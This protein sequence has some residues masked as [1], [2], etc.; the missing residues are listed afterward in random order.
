MLS[1][2][3]RF[4]QSPLGLGIF[5][6]IIVAFIV[7]LYE[8]NGGLG[9]VGGGA[10]VA[11][12]GGKAIDEAELTRRVQNQLEGERQRDPTIDMAKFVAGGGVEQTIDLTATGRALEVFATRQG[13][14]A[15]KKLVDGAIASIPAFNGPTGQFDRA[16]F[17]NVLSSRKISETMLRDD[18]GREALTKALLI[19]ASGAARIPTLMVQPYAS[20]LLEQRQGSVAE[21]PSAAFAGGPAPGDAEIQA[22]YRANIARYTV[23]E[24]RVIRYATFDKTRFAGKVAATDA[25]I[26]QAYKAAGAEYAARDKRAFT[27]VIVPNQADADAVLAKI[28]GGMSIA[29]AA[30][31]V[32]RDAVSVPLTDKAGFDKLTGNAVSAAAFAAPQGGFA[33]VA[34]SALGFHVVRVDSVAT[35]PAT[36]LSA[37]REKLSGDITKAKEARAIADYVAQIEDGIAGNATFDELTKK[38]GLTAVTS[39]ALTRD[40]RSFT[41]AT[42]Q[43]TAAI[44]AVIG[45]AFQSE[46]GDDPAIKTFPD[47]SG[48]ALWKT[49]R[50]V[51]AAPKPLTELRAQVIADVQRDRGAKAAKAVADRI[52]AAIN[53]GMPMAQAVS[54]AGVKLPPLRPLAVSRMD[55]AKA[56]GKVPPPIAVL[57]QLPVKRARALPVP[58]QQGW[59]V[60]TVDAIRSADA[61]SVPG[62][63][64]GTRQQLAGT[65]G[66]EYV[67]Q[68]ASAVRAEI[69]VKK[70]AAGIARLKRSLTGGG[71][72]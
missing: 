11:E 30:R 67:Q 58:D 31:S 46:P 47:G 65:I 52:V 70:N 26:E 33:A 6:L 60:V 3:R 7:T 48:Y 59:F 20:L 54:Q 28:K 61:R 8:G 13:M 15:S 25:E 43:S 24:Q 4:S 27:Q 50:V 63:I 17:L 29:E 23:P 56:Q 12:V 21:V 72:Q 69:G 10:S 41:A 39:P 14:V 55:L 36:P 34:R 2:F 57:F 38:F 62:L 64:E 51:P 40:G 9:G 71:G 1:F 68:F 53:G 37:V 49:D 19:P 16:T 44:S 42:G 45:D 32:K 5:A 35:I 66:D 22:F 18:F